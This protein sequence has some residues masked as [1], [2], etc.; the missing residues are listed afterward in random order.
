MAFEE[1][2]S[3][4]NLCQGELKQEFQALMPLVVG[5]LQEGER[6]SITIK[7]DFQKMKDTTTMLNVNYSIKPT[8]PAKKRA[9]I[10]QIGENFRVKTNKVPER[11]DNLTLFKKEGA[12]NE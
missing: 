7:V 10:C 5:C 3:L 8:Y 2:L 9:S 11:P 1:V 12:V 6:G 4:E